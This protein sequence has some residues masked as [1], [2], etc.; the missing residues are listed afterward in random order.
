MASRSSRRRVRRASSRNAAT[1]SMSRAGATVPTTTR[2]SIVM[3][4]GSGSSCLSQRPSSRAPKG[5]R[6][7][8]TFRTCTRCASVS[9]R[10]AASSTGC[11]SASPWRPRL[12]C[13]QFDCVRLFSLRPAASWPVS[14]SAVSWL[15]FPR[16]L[17]ALRPFRR[18]SCQ[19]LRRRPSRRAPSSR[20]PSRATSRAALFGRAAWP[21]T[22]VGVSML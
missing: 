5:N 21:R 10:G 17:G 6:R 11:S 18:R 12:A 1:T 22:A 3:T 8:R 13:P 19:S 4:G 15:R 20:R 16:A 9:P 14:S 2:S 7:T